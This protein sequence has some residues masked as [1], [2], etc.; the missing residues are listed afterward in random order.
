[1]K[2][3]D[4]NENKPLIYSEL[5]APA[6]ETNR[7]NLQCTGVGDARWRRGIELCLPVIVLMGGVSLLDVR[8]IEEE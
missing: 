2:V 6:G 5:G 4:A 8:H 1:M 7:A 3:V